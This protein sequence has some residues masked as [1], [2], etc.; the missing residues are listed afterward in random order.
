VNSFAEVS[1]DSANL[2]S[3]MIVLIFK[4]FFEAA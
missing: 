2:E 1:F 4:P 3:K